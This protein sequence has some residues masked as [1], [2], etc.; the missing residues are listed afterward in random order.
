M[1]RFAETNEQV[2]QRWFPERASLFSEDYS[3]LPEA[4]PAIDFEADF[5]GACSVIV[6][7]V[8]DAIRQ[9]QLVVK[10]QSARAG[11][12][13]ETAR[14]RVA[15]TKAVKL[16]STDISSRLALARLQID[17]GALSTA[18]HHLDLALK[19]HPENP[20]ALRLKKRLERVAAA[21]D[22]S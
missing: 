7:V 18:R 22:S 19:S 9:Q 11:K 6:E 13:K 14:Q 2:R 17:E 5:K 4:A 15:L 10:A 21:I 8:L 12:A 3:H 1:A 16:D 20:L